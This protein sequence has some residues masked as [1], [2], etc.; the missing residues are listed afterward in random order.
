MAKAM[1]WEGEEEEKE[2]G[3]G[4]A[5][6]RSLILASTSCVAKMKSQINDDLARLYN[7]IYEPALLAKKC[8]CEEVAVNWSE[9]FYMKSY[10][11][12]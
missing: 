9:A 10:K 5:T 6:E 8:Y 11:S 4:V 7:M 3:G 12:K 2:G 1:N